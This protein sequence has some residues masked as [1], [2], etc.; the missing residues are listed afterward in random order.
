MGRRATSLAFRGWSESQTQLLL[1]CS[2]LRWCRAQCQSAVDHATLRVH[3]ELSGSSP[4][5]YTATRK[6]F[7]N[8]G[9]SV[10]EPDIAELA[11]GVTKLHEAVILDCLDK[12]WITRCGITWCGRWGWWG[13]GR[14]HGF[15]PRQAFVSVAEECR[16]SSGGRGGSTAVPFGVDCGRE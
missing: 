13:L 15:P 2:Q 14:V 4:R 7:S 11:A 12:G 6:V 1:E 9:R 16:P 8:S 10:A 3:D 5:G